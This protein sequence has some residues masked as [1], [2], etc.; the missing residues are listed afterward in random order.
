MD[1][2]LGNRTTE[3]QLLAAARQQHLSHAYLLTGPA[4]SGKKTLAHWMS[5][6]FMCSDGGCGE[7]LT[8]QKIEKRVHPDVI[9][10]EPYKKSGIYPVEQIRDIRKDALIY[11]NEGTHK[12]YIIPN[13]ENMNGNAQDAFL[14]ILEEPPEFV[15]FI[16]LCNDESK[17]LQTILSRVVRYS[18]ALPEQNDALEYLRAHSDADDGRLRQA[19]GMSGGNIG[20]ALALLQD[21]TTARRIADC[22]DF[23][24]TLAGGTPY[25]LAA[26]AHAKAKDKEEFAAFVDLLSI[27][28]RDVLVDKTAN[29]QNLVFQDSIIANRIRFSA[30]RVSKLAAAVVA[31]QQL[32]VDCKQ[33]YSALLLETKLVTICLAI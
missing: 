17:L 16:L 27:Y 5:R 22:E 20:Q 18:M 3:Q 19:L 24:L 13:V 11:P 30:L 32:A 25:D 26:K 9:W 33:P 10:A 7:C 15:I 6:V 14:K 2:L 31:L 12:I 8:C 28:L 23:C 4:G 1:C 29:G 21:E